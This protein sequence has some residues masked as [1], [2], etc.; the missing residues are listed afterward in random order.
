MN[1][2][3]VWLSGLLLVSLMTLASCGGPARNPPL[4]SVVTAHGNTDWH[5]DTAEESLYGT[6]LNGAA[7][8]ANHVP[9]TW[10][11]RHVHGGLS[12][13]DSF[14]RRQ[15]DRGSPM[16]AP[17]GPAMLPDDE[18]RTKTGIRSCDTEAVT[19]LGPSTR[20]PSHRSTH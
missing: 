1:R 3:S 8:A 16:T 12:N 14:C 13:T 6:D 20:D 11:R 15:P 10:T 7:S 9:D 18:T 19:R 2:S 17:R 5:I 4:D